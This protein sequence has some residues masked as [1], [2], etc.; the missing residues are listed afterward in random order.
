MKGHLILL[1]HAHMPYVK[2]PRGRFKAKEHW[3]F[4]A[5]CE[6]YIPL[7]KAFQSLRLSKCTISISPTLLSMLTED[8]FAKRFSQYLS[9]RSDIAHREL[10]RLKGTV[11]E[12]LITLY[13]KQIEDARD[14]AYTG[15]IT[16]GLKALQRG[17]DI[18][19]IST[20]A[21]HAYLPAQTT[22]AIYRQVSHGIEKFAQVFGYMPRGFWLPEC[23]YCPEVKS[24]LK[25]CKLKY[26]FLSP[27]SIVKLPETSIF[28]PFE[29]STNLYAFALDTKTASKIWCAK[30]GY[31]ANAHYREF[32]RDIGFELPAS[33]TGLTAPD[34]T[35]FKYY[36]ITSLSSDDKAPYDAGLAYSQA[37][38][39]ASDFVNYLD[40]RFAELLRCLPTP[41][42]VLAFDAELF[43]HWWYEGVLWLKEFV[44]LTHLK[45]SNYTISLPLEILSNTTEFAMCTLQT[46]SW[47]RASDSSTWINPKTSSY[48]RQLHKM[49]ALYEH[50]SS[51]HISKQVLDKLLRQ[52]QLAESSDW[53]FMLAQ[54]RC[55]DY[56]Q[57][58]LQRHIR[59]FRRLIKKAYLYSI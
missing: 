18:E 28:V 59:S 7:L 42:I 17:G 32:Y 23:G 10:S 5:M 36:R 29:V 52:L 26:F 53:M 40:E 56:A 48:Y 57:H 21:T 39:D 3:L 54:N 37:L 38:A 20:S 51:G 24:V 27:A 16:N 11:F 58:R 4:E 41:I 1:L 55:E 45:A 25:S 22:H 44:R 19:L 46:G 49:Q 15:S 12:G 14:F 13:I 9:W 47:G 35:G 43:G 8:Y 33:Y 6:C 31:P 34:F 50:L 30:T 2:E